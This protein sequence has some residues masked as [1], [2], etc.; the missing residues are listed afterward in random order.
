MADAWGGLEFARIPRWDQLATAAG[1][2]DEG[3]RTEDEQPTINRRG[4]PIDFPE[5]DRARHVALFGRGIDHAE[6][7]G[8]EVGLLV[9]MH[10]AGLYRHRLGLDGPEPDEHHPA[11]VDFLAREDSRQERLREALGNDLELAGWTWDA[12][13]LLQAF[14]SLSLYLVWRGLGSGAPGALLQTPRALGDPGVDIACESL[15]RFTASCEPFPFEGDEVELPVS[16]RAIPDRPYR[17][18]DDLRRALEDGQDVTLECVVCR[19][20]GGGSRR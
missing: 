17:D 12:Y 6:T 13:R 8:P 16:A 15:G 1:C 20:P 14:D 10:G 4:F 3:W 2:H 19:R 11:V 5:I 7:I 18:A 9:S